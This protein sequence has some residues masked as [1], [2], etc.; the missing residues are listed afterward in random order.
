MCGR[1]QWPTGEVMEEYRMTRFMARALTLL[2]GPKGDLM[3][4]SVHTTAMIP[5]RVAWTPAQ[6]HRWEETEGFDAC[7]IDTFTHWCSYVFG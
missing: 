2:S 3:C 4:N 1:T 6:L 5:L 7:G